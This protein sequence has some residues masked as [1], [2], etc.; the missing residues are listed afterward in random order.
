MSLAQ[1]RQPVTEEATGPETEALEADVAAEKTEQAEAF[2]H[3]YDEMDAIADQTPPPPPPPPFDAGP[4]DAAERAVQEDEAIQV[5]VPAPPPP[6]P[7]AL[8][9]VDL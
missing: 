2:K 5:A 9:T 3:L 1:G 8:P 6:L 4:L 7:A